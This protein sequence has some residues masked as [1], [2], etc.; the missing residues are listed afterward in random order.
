MRRRVFVKRGFVRM[1]LLLP[2]LILSV[3][4]CYDY[5]YAIDST[6][7]ST[8]E[9]KRCLTNGYQC[10]LR[11]V[12]EDVNVIDRCTFDINLNSCVWIDGQCYTKTCEN[13]TNFSYKTLGMQ[14][15]FSN[16]HNQR[17][18]RMYQETNCQNYQIKEACYTDCQNVECIWDDT[19]NKCFSNQCLYF[20][21]DGILSSKEEKCDD[22]NYLP[23]DGCQQCQVQCPQGC[24]ICNG[25]V[26]EDCHMKGWVLIKGISNSFC[27]DWYIEGNEFCEIMFIL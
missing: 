9:S 17:R 25:P 19:L 13:F 1:G 8:F 7:A 26:C 4:E 24:N 27:G 11:K 15:I 12:C 10:V 5:N 20:C 16:L 18:R 23:Y 3:Q 21:G 14:F 6:C 2:N 22:G